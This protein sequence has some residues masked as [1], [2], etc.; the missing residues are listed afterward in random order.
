MKFKRIYILY[1]NLHKEKNFLKEILTQS[2]F[3]IPL[4][5]EI[6]NVTSYFL[7]SGKNLKWKQHFHNDKFWNYQLL[8]MFGGAKYQ[9]G[10]E[11]EAGGTDKPPIDTMWRNFS[12]WQ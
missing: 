2:L 12:V 3:K 1:S 8:S 6:E 10:Y 7:I 9:G 5:R 4:W 11:A